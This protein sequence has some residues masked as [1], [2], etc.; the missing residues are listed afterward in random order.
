[1]GGTLLSV[2]R[3][4]RSGYDLRPAAF[5]QSVVLCGVPDVRDYRIRSTAEQAM[6]A[7]GSAFNI[8]AASWRLGDFSRDD[9]LALIGQHT[10][11]T[12]QTFTTGALETIWRQTRGQP[13]LVNALVDDACL[14]DKGAGTG[15]GPSTRRPSARRRSG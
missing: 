15:R 2:L 5:P 13:W 7:G 9:G 8:R 14:R 10:A 4:L 6:V 3:Q 12:G 1:M 11:E